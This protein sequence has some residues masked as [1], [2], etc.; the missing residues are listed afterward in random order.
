MDEEGASVTSL[1]ETATVRITHSDIILDTGGLRDLD[2]LAFLNDALKPYVFSVKLVGEEWYVSD[3]KVRLM[4]LT[5]PLVI[6]GAATELAA[7][8]TPGAGG[9]ARVV[10][11]A[12][13]RFR[14]Y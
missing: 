10:K 1:L 8:P 14:P 2:C 13:A 6:T 3:G 4:R 12:A 11:P 5:D 9:P 7:P